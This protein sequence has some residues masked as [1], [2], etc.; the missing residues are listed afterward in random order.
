MSSDEPRPRLRFIDAWLY[1]CAYSVVL[2]A[3]DVW[4]GFHIGLNDYWGGYYQA[5]NIDFTDP[6]TLYEGFFPIGYPVLLRLAPGDDFIKAGFAIAAACRILLI[7][8][9]GTLAL[10]LLSRAWA[11]MAM[12]ALSFV[13]RVFENVLTPASDLPMMT[14]S[15][16]GSACF[17]LAV[18]PEGPRS[19]RW[20]L[21]LAGGALLGLSGLIRQHALVFA[22][23]MMLGAAVLRPRDIGRIFVSGLVCG[24]AYSPQ[25]VVNLLA[26]RGPLETAQYVNVYKIVH[27][28]NEVRDI[29]L[30]LAPDVPAIIAENPFR[31]FGEWSRHFFRM[32]PLLVPALLSA[33]YL[34]D[35]VLR[36]AGRMIAIAGLL[37]LA[38]VASGWSARAVL[39]VV[40]WAVLLAAW[41][42][43]RAQSYAARRVGVRMALGAMLGCAMFL[44]AAWASKQNAN[45]VRYYLQEHHYYS[46]VERALTA[47]GVVHPKQ[48]Y[49]TDGSLYFPMTPPH[50]PYF[51]GSWGLF[52]LYKYAE[53][54]PRLNAGT[55]AEFHDDCLRQGITHIA[56]DYRARDV[57]AALEDLYRNPEVH[58]EFQ[59]MGRIGIYTL[60]RR[61][62]V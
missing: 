56:L 44:L 59:Y 61:S 26:H 42:A 40:P 52:T 17:F 31:F 54:Y 1:A 48:V 34:R 16:A 30:D 47:D 37:Y 20:A 13:P 6:Q 9:F 39:P 29:P 3:L 25:I 14:L 24:L 57:S 15:L 36:R 50:W 53:R 55:L 28:L 32:L 22:A 60:F 43:Q 4:T 8:A 23:G 41:L 62:D 58:A 49:A 38:V 33:L 27:G 46:E 19:R 10:R 45:L 2:L 12:V 51:D 11:M 7:G 21:Y 35:P 5:E 18:V